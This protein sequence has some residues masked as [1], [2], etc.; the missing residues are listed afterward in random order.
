MGLLGRGE[1]QD[2][3]AGARAAK[4]KCEAS[5]RV[6]RQSTTARSMAFCSSRTLPGQG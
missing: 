1:R 2:V 6:P 3:A 4:G 5:M